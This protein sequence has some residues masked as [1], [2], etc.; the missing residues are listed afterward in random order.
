MGIKSKKPTI[1]EDVTPTAEEKPKKRSK[2]E[3]DAQP[4]PA[5]IEDGSKKKRSKKGDN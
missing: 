5:E 1:A 2:A 3:S 4:V